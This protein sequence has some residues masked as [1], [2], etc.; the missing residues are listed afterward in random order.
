M[1]KITFD[2]SNALTF[3]DSNIYNNVKKDFAIAKKMLDDKNG[4]GNDFLGWLDLPNNYDNNDLH[5]IKNIAAKIRNNSDVLI[6]VGIGGSYLG[7]KAAIDMLN[8]RMGLN[9]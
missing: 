8:N 2:D 1:N 4:L 7:S 6:V 3:F 9:Y 5:Q